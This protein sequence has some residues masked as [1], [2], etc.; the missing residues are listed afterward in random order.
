LS[1]VRNAVTGGYNIDGNHNCECPV[2]SSASEVR[3]M[4]EIDPN[5]DESDTKY[6]NCGNVD[7]GDM[8]YQC[9]VDDLYFCQ[10]CG[11]FVRNPFGNHNCICPEYHST[12]NVKILGEIG[13]DEQEEEDLE[14]SA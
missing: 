4:G 5:A 9:K 12:S 13:G 3:I 6:K 14:E 8:L 2:C 10:Q 7:P 11:Y 1:F